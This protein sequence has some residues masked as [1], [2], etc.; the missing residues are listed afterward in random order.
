MS[1]KTTR[2][3]SLEP[4][5]FTA[6]FGIEPK[7]HRDGFKQCGFARTVLANEK[8]YRWMKFKSFKMLNHRNTKGVFVKAFDQFTFKPNSIKK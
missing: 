3:T 7:F 5:I 8:S 2:L 4:K 1:S 6:A